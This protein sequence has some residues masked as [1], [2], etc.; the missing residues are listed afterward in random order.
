MTSQESPQIIR[1]IPI[2]IQRTV[3]DGFNF[4]GCSSTN[5]DICNCATWDDIT[6]VICGDPIEDGQDIESVIF[7][8]N[9]WN[10]DGNQFDEHWHVDCGTEARKYV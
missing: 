7:P 5:P 3:A 10:P 9:W 8:E 1:T 4:S 2:E 6:C